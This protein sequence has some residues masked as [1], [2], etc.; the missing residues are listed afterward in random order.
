VADEDASNGE[1]AKGTKE[2]AKAN[3]ETD[4]SDVTNKKED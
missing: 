3:K 4:T 2:M 1:D